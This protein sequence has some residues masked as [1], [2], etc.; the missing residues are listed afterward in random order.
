M[1]TFRPIAILMLLVSISTN[2]QERSLLQCSEVADDIAR[3]AC[4][5]AAAAAVKASLEKPQVGSEAQ[6]RERRDAEVAAVVLGDTVAEE[7]EEQAPPQIAVTIKEVLFT[8]RRETIYATSDGRLWEK[9][10]DQAGGL[11]E[12]DRVILE[13]GLFGSIFMINEDRGVRIKVKQ[14]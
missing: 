1:A 6:R 10:T 11:R 7:V 2:A 14:R 5:D 3:L 9:V 12:G 8:R 13:D 4:Y